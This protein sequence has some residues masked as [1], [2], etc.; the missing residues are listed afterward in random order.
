MWAMSIK[1]TLFYFPE[2]SDDLG[3]ITCFTAT[4]SSCFLHWDLQRTF[5]SQS[6]YENLTYILFPPKGSK[7][8]QLLP[9][10]LPIRKGMICLICSE[11]DNMKAK[12]ITQ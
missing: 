5:S 2:L 6:Y 1:K 11:S 4:H 12:E 9:I 10:S 8:F 3:T 7:K